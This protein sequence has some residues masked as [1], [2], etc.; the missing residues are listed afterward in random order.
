MTA[1]TLRI[2]EKKHIS[3]FCGNTLDL[4]SNKLVMYKIHHLKS[5]GSNIYR[6]L[7]FISDKFNNLLLYQVKLAAS[8]NL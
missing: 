1:K 5:C 3:Q 4:K 7:N 6:R 8:Q 2:Y